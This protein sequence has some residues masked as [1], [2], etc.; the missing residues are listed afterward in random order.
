VNFG[1]DEPLSFDNVL[2]LLE[3]LGYLAK[4]GGAPQFWT[5][6]GVQTLMSLLSLYPTSRLIVLEVLWILKEM[7][8]S[9]G[10]NSTVGIDS[11]LL[12]IENETSLPADVRSEVLHMLGAALAVAPPSTHLAFRYNCL[13]QY[14]C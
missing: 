6:H 1:A 7:L 14:K 11:I 3:A 13:L 4:S 8:T 10:E 9:D 12:S 5:H 2:L